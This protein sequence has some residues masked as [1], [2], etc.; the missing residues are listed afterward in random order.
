M[1]PLAV[2]SAIQRGCLPRPVQ[3]S[4]G[5]AGLR[6]FGATLPSLRPAVL[7]GAL[8]AGAALRAR[9]AGAPPNSSSMV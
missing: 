1:L 9:G 3:V 5:L 2:S 7:D 4:L 6:Y 8:A